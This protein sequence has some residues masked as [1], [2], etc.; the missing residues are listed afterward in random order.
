MQP[1]AMP[2][3]MEPELK[4][5]GTELD[6]MEEDNGEESSKRP[7]KCV[8]G[9]E[10]YDSGRRVRAKRSRK[11]EV[12]RDQSRRTCELRGVVSRQM[13]QFFSC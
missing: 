13:L 4:Q 1:Q 7:D 5:E 9:K 11:G 10:S 2:A 3:A 6:E 8:Q 12:G